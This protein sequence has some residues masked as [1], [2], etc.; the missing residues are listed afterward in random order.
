MVLYKF[1]DDPG[2]SVLVFETLVVTNFRYGHCVHVQFN[3]GRFLFSV[4]FKKCTSCDLITLSNMVAA[5]R[6]VANGYFSYSVIMTP[7]IAYSP[8]LLR[9]YFCLWYPIDLGH[10]SEIH[11]FTSWFN[12]VIYVFICCIYIWACTNM[13]EWLFCFYFFCFLALYQRK[14]YKTSNI[15]HKVFVLMVST[16]EILAFFL[17]FQSTRYSV[18][19]EHRGAITSLNLVN[20]GIYICSL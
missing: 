15:T 7:F 4:I 18:T 14:T 16:W 6:I 2:H 1:P 10:W 8:R 5:L 9:L 13:Y 11:H 20:L 17:I 12:P 19:C 3:T